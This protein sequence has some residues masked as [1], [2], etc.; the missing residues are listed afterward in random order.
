MRGV[1]LRLTER[2]GARACPS[3]FRLSFL[4]GA[5]FRP[6]RVLSCRAGRKG[7]L[8]PRG[9]ISPVC[10]LS[11]AHASRPS[12]IFKR[13]PARFA[14]R[15]GTSPARA[16]QYKSCFG[17][18]AALRRYVPQS[19]DFL[20]KDRFFRAKN[21]FVRLPGGKKRRFFKFFAKYI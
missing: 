9:D 15:G 19:G 2:L 13:P 4:C 3:F 17:L 16:K 12:A 8:P 14:V 6:P 7:S 11:A 18:T 1:S 21:A 10:L 5:L 20:C